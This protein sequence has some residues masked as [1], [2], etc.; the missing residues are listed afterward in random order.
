MPAKRKAAALAPAKTLEVRL[1]EA[2]GKMRCD[3]PDFLSDPGRR[4]ILNN[5]T[6]TEFKMCIA[7]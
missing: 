7:I 3:V 6:V 2:A 5:V 1:W 4:D